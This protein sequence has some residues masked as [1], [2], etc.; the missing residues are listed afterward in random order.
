[1]AVKV[2]GRGATPAVG[3]TS[4]EQVMEQAVPVT[5][6]VPLFAQLMPESVATIDQV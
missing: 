5:L 4:A 6:L 1:L 3:I 2:T